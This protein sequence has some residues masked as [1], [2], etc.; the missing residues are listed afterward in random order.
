MQTTTITPTASDKTTSE[1]LYANLASAMIAGKKFADAN[2][3][4]FFAYPTAFTQQYTNS[5]PT[6][7]YIAKLSKNKRK[8]L[9]RML[10]FAAEFP[11]YSRFHRL[12]RFVNAHLFSGKE[13]CKISKG[14][15]ELAI[16][17]AQRE[18]RAAQAAFATAQA[19]YKKLKADFYKVNRR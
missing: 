15:D 5:L 17:K 9:A 18:Y 1:A 19:T 12:T 11:S 2:Y 4:N 13:Q 16:E 10:Y 7:E 14:N 8:Q 3:Y 6:K